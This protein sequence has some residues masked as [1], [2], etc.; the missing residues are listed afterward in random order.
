MTTRVFKIE[1]GLLIL[2]LAGYIYF[3]NNFIFNVANRQALLRERER[4]ELTISTFESQ[5]LTITRTIT[6][7]RAYALG[8]EEADVNTA[9]AVAATPHL[10]FGSAKSEA[11]GHEE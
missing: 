6:I 1:I 7:E 10:A 5:Y 3:V 4:L 2:A 8:F 11:S 9:F